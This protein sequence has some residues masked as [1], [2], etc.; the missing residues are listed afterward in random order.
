MFEI[1]S[2]GRVECLELVDESEKTHEE[3]KNT[4]L[5]RER[6]WKDFIFEESEDEKKASSVPLDPHYF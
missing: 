4:S 1:D 3:G 6:G 2:V 5:P